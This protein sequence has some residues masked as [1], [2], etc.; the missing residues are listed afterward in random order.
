MVI[1]MSL[2]PDVAGRRC[3][4]TSSR[5]PH[6]QAECHGIDDG[7]GGPRG[8][9]AG[10]VL[11]ETALE[12]HPHERHQRHPHHQRRQHRQH[13]QGP[14]RLSVPSIAARR[15]CT[16]ARS[17]TPRGS[18]LGS[19]GVTAMVEPGMSASPL[20]TRL[21]TLPRLST[22]RRLST[23][24]G[25][26]TVPR[27]AKPSRQPLDVQERGSRIEDSPRRHSTANGSRQL[28][29]GHATVLRWGSLARRWM[30]RSFRHS[31]SLRN[32][33]R[34]KQVA[35]AATVRDQDIFLPAQTRK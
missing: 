35:L 34:I 20:W 2:A 3:P 21:S 18:Q 11:L 14:W 33:S 24:P 27:R 9:D 4:S 5:R 25:R 22:A 17:R 16:C 13:H 10:P 6:D 29:D 31:I 12:E 15:G 19:E 8:G 23:V 7:R 28:G 1:A 26:S 32:P 30:R